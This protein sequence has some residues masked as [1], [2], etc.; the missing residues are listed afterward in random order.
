M[1]YLEAGEH[2]AVAVNHEWCLTSK[3]TKALCVRFE[4]V[5][6]EGQTGNFINWWGYF[7]EKAWE[8][9]IE[10]LRHM[11]FN[12]DDL[13]SLGELNQKVSLSVIEDE[14]E[15]RIRPKV[16]WVNALGNKRILV[17]DVM[18]QKTVGQ[19]AAAMKNRIASMQKGNS[20]PSNGVPGASESN[21]EIP[22]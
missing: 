5:N 3:G 7:S 16:A 8:R 1:T 14:Y 12:G 15:G 10:S 9:T 21:D 6:H 18:D 11:G 22:F 17:N 2:Q 4:V 20:I 19:F 13:T